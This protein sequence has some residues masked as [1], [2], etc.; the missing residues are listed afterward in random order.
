MRYR[1]DDVRDAKDRVYTWLSIAVIAAGVA[2]RLWQFFGGSAL[3]TDEATIANSIVG[4]TLP[5]LVFAPLA[6]YQAAPLGFL[7]IERLIVTLFGVNELAL[8][9]YPVACAILSLLVLWRIARHLLPAAS[10]PMTLAPFAFAPQLI[11]HAAEV[12]QY[13]SDIAVALGLL[14]LALELGDREVSGGMTMRFT[15]GA[16]IAGALSVWLSQPAVLVVTGLGI[17]LAIGTLGGRSR[18]PIAPLAW[19]IGAWALSALAAT[20]VSMQHLTPDARRYMHVFWSDGFWPLSLRHPSSILWPIAHIALLVGSQLG[21]PTSIGLAWALLATV[22]IVGAWK[23]EWRVSLLLV[24]PLVVALG[25]AAAYLYPFAERLALF[26]LPSLL[27]LA[28]IG[29]REIAASARGKHGPAAVL[30]VATLFVFAVEIRALLAAPPE[31]R[32]EEIT[33]ALAYLRHASRAA[34]ASYVYYGGIPAYEFYDAREPFPLRATL[35]GCHRGDASAYLAELDAFR[36]RARVWL[37]FAHEL[38]RLGEREMMLAHLDSL[39]VERD[40]LTVKGRDTSGNATFVRL[41]LYDLSAT[42]PIDTTVV[43]AIAGANVPAIE[44]RLQCPPRGEQ[45]RSLRLRR[46][47]A[48]GNRQSDR[49]AA[50]GPRANEQRGPWAIVDAFPMLGL[51]ASCDCDA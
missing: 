40:S 51:A 43:R 15:A 21:V 4:R 50:A 41:Y 1:Q 22:G 25:A 14:L 46:P 23:T 39:G 20:V 12:K 49:E 8:R 36:G 42:P 35:G 27:L 16:A 44:P 38:P 26:V 5:E 32:R 13:S 6:H 18:R 7:A 30:A 47:G 45:R 11:A 3:W 9:A 29:V 37:L 34:D 10:V 31:F 19:I 33:P 28:A 2:L 24:M 48:K 17:A